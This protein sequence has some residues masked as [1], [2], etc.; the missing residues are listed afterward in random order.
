MYQH[1][2]LF[3]S[4]LTNDARRHGNVPTAFEFQIALNTDCKNQKIGEGFGTALSLDEAAKYTSFA[5]NSFC[6]KFDLFTDRDSDDCL[7]IC[8]RL[9]LL[10][11]EFVITRDVSMDDCV[12]TQV[13]FKFVAV[14]AV[15]RRTALNGFADT[16]VMQAYGLTSADMEKFKSLFH[17][18]YT[19]ELDQA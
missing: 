13:S 2:Y 17:K 11:S 10:E 18:L 1:D 9:N 12:F 4:I 7:L 14:I 19:Q 8:G 3:Y 6:R 16:F 15:M 5:E